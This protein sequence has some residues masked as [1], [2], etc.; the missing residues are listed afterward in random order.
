MIIGVYEDLEMVSKLVMTI[1]MVAF[2]GGVLDGAV[3]PL[4]LAV[5]P[6]VVRLCQSVL[7]AVLAADL[8]EAMDPVARGP[9]ITIAWEVGEL[10]A[11]VSKNDVKALGHCFEQRFQERDRGRPIRLF[12]KLNK[13]ELRG[14]IDPDIEVELALFS[15]DL[16]DIDVEVADR[17]AL[18]FCLAGLR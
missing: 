16:S 14:A 2:D 5:G 13:G 4:D 8:V 1:V 10:D 15:A 9:S 3:H 12:M 18:N 6:R 17:Y 7:D 11:I